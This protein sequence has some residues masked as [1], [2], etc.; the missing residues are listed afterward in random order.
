MST[1]GFNGFAVAQLFQ[2]VDRLV[3]ELERPLDDGGADEAVAN[4]LQRLFFLVED[5]QDQFVLGLEART[6]SAM[7]GLL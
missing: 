1:N 4:G 3:A 5:D 2:G 7:H 6:A